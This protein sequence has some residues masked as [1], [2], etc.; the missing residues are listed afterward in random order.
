[1]KVKSEIDDE[2]LVAKLKKNKC[3]VCYL[4]YMENV[5]KELDFHK[6]NS[7]KRKLLLKNIQI[8]LQECDK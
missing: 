4:E 7:L 5:I 8:V 2:K 1:V 3:N 6:K